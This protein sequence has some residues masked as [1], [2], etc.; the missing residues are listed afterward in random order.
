MKVYCVE[1]GYSYEDTWLEK[2]F[3]TR[4]KAD[5]Y[6]IKQGC[7]QRMA[8]G[9]DTDWANRETLERMYVTEMEVE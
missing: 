7:D 6:C 2:V 4:Q 8:E 1:H 5:E 3:D 9:I